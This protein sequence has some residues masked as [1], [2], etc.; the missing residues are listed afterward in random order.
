MMRYRWKLLILKTKKRIGDAMNL[1]V[2]LLVYAL[3]GLILWEAWEMW[4]EEEKN[5]H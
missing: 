2:L 4:K 5:E 1:I 3:V